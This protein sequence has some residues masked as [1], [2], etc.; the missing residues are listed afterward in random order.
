MNSV[1]TRFRVVGSRLR[2]LPDPAALAPGVKETIKATE[3][4][5]K[6]WRCAV[7]SHFGDWDSTATWMAKGSEN[8][9]P[10]KDM[11][12]ALGRVNS[13]LFLMKRWIGKTVKYGA[14]PANDILLRKSAVGVCRH[15]VSAVSHHRAARQGSG[16]S[17]GTEEDVW[18]GLRLPL[19][20]CQA[21]MNLEKGLSTAEC[22][23]EPPVWPE[24]EILLSRDEEGDRGRDTPCSTD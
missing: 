13:S 22:K 8:Q 20:A 23:W 15:V 18:D 9:E 11:I 2:E 1:N 19:E 7:Y 4:M 6:D 5:F 14:E 3:K 21:L 12:I 16:I 10:Y 24:I 17:R